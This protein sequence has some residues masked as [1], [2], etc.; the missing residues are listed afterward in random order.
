[1]IK[2]DFS[3]TIAFFLFI[4]LLLVF[5]KWVIYNYSKEDEAHPSLQVTQ[6]PYCTHL[7]FDFGKSLYKTCPNCKSLITL[8][9]ESNKKG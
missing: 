5:L 3:V 4:S 6:C 7:F 1:M 9:D 8:Q 2:L